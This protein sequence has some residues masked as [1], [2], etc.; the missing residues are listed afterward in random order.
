MLTLYRCRLHGEN[1]LAQ[2]CLSRSSHAYDKHLLSRIGKPSS[3]PQTASLGPGNNPTMVK[4]LPLHARDRSQLH[5]LS[6][7]AI[8]AGSFDPVSR[9]VRNPASALSP[10]SRQAWRDDSMVVRSPSIDGSVPSSAT[11]SDSYSRLREDNQRSTRGSY[12]SADDSVSLPT[13]SSRDSYDHFV[14]AESEAESPMEATGRMRRLNLADSA[15][16]R[17]DERLSLSK[18]GMKRRA[19]SPPVETSHGE[20]VASH[21]ATTTCDA[22]PRTTLVSSFPRS[23]GSR[24]HLKHGSFSSTSSASLRNN[25]LASSIGLSVAGSSMTSASSFERHSPGGISPSSDIDLSQDSSYVTSV[26][27][28]PNSCTLLNP[29]RL[30]RTQTPPARTSSVQST[31]NKARKN[32][33]SRVGEIVICECCPKKP[34]KFHNEEELRQVPRVSILETLHVR[35]SHEFYH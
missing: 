32:N 18:Q 24:V 4:S 23:P 2:E 33:A 25:S 26:S 22:Y 7:S 34:R 14:F 9:W 5:R 31:V 3:P 20:K 27:L 8:S 19:I 1:P 35:A 29:A 11:D 17:T 10:G 21:C 16:S 13:R 15:P 6:V 12:P 30:P 28:N